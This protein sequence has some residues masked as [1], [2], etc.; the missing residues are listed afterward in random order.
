MNEELFNV[1]LNALAPKTLAYLIRDLDETQADWRYY[2]E[3]AP[4]E[5]VQ[6]ELQQML[7]TIKALAI[8]RAAAEGV[9]FARLLQQAN[10][11]QRQEEWTSQRN[12]QVQQN[13]LNDLQ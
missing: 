1:I 11:E 6:Q 7:E 8:E 10:E 12:T 2:S 5:G 13:W 4:P 9:D 3:D